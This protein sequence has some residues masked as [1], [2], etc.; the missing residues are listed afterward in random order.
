VKSNAL[1]LAAVPRQKSYYA[2]KNFG[3]HRVATEFRNNGLDTQV[4]HYFNRFTDT[5]LDKLILQYCNNNTRIV[6]FNTMFWEN[7]EESEKIYVLKKARYVCEKIKSMF[8]DIKIIAGGP[9]CRIFLKEEYSG[10]IDAIFEGFS[11][12]DFIPY[13]RNEVVFPNKVYH[14]IKVFNNVHGTFNFTTSNT[15]YTKND[16]L[17]SSETPTLEVG[18]GC[19]FKCKFCAFALNGKK[20]LDYIKDAKILEDEL[21]YNYENF[22]FTNYILSDDTF[23]DST[24]KIELLHKVF[25]NLPFK[26]NFSSYLRL[27]LLRAHPEQIPLLKEMGL[28]GAFFGIESFHKKASSLIGKGMDPDIAKE[29]LMDLKDNKWGNNIKIGVGL[30]TGLPYETYESHDKTMEWILDENNTVDQ[31]IPFPL[32]V[33]NPNNA[34]PQP[35]ESEFQI[36]ATKYGFSWPNNDSVRWHNSIGPVKSLDE[37]ER[38]Y[39][40]YSE[41]VSKTAR[42]KQG[43]FNLL[44]AYPLIASQKTP[45]TI[46]QLLSMNRYAYTKY[47][48]LIEQ[49][50]EIE[51]NYVNSYKEEILNAL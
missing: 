41:C 51:L 40:L 29:M 45:P 30:I 22:G 28:I 12:N 46:D 49:Q 23:N 9:S 10:L 27:D 16:F 19:I 5:E 48:K 6:G 17:K 24:Y 33:T 42:W 37:A 31:V 44:K 25:T 14:D 13:I 1:L 50:P 36:N 32:G 3:V 26:L 20:K 35:W 39:E 11:E 47:I 43:G 4:I 38:I 8:P 18:R 21:V 2:S 34:K 15:I 7:Y